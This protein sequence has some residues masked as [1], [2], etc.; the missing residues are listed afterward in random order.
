MHE[1]K[2]SGRQPRTFYLSATTKSLSS[3]S[4]ASMHGIKKSRRRRHDWAVFEE[5]IKIAIDSSVVKAETQ[6]GTD[7]SG[8]GTGMPEGFEG[9]QLNSRVQPA[10]SAGGEIPTTAYLPEAPDRDETIPRPQ[11]IDEVT[12]CLSQATLQANQDQQIDDSQMQPQLKFQPKPPKPRCTEN[13]LSAT[14]LSPGGVVLPDAQNSESQ[15]DF[16]YD[17]YLRT[18]KQPKVGYHPDHP[19]NIDHQLES[20]ADGKVGILVI[21]EQDEAVWETYAEDEESDNKDW[22]SE[23]EDENGT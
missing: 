20:I 14:G 9:K 15:D 4:M 12:D 3:P 11:Q 23:D 10:V 2:Q 18:K 13:R 16:V 17:T 6:N 7:L 22:N 5:K 8:Q 1:T 21:G 19:M